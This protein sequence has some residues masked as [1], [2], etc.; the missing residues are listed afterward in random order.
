MVGEHERQRR[1]DRP[2]MRPRR[3]RPRHS[4]PYA[5]TKAWAGVA[6]ATIGG[7]ALVFITLQMYYDR[8][9]LQERGLVTTGDIVAV[10]YGRSGPTAAVRFA[11]ADGRTVQANVSNPGDATEVEVG[12]RMQV[13]YDPKDPTRRVRDADGDADAPWPVGLGGVVLLVAA[14]YSAARVRT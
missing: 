5:N 8:R 7:L 13:R 1:L 2:A 11:T 9:I 14:A 6:C 3:R 12:A 4:A 10:S